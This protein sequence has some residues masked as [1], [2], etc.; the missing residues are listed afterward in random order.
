M[1]KI[2]LL[3]PIIFLFILLGGCQ[4]DGNG[5]S[6]PEKKKDVQFTGYFTTNEVDSNHTIPILF[7][8]KNEGNQAIKVMEDDFVLEPEDPEIEHG[9]GASTGEVPRF[10]TVEAHEEAAIIAHYLVT[11]N[12]ALETV[13]ARDFH[14]QY[15]GDLENVHYP[16]TL[17]DEVPTEYAQ[18][19]ADWNQESGTNED[20]ATWAD[21]QNESDTEIVNGF[22][23]QH[24]FKV[25]GYLMEDRGGGHVKVHI[26]VENLTDKEQTF[27][28]DLL[29]IYD[30]KQEYDLAPETDSEFRSLIPIPR[31]GKVDYIQYYLLID[32]YESDTEDIM[33][34]IQGFHYIDD[35][36]MES[37][38]VYGNYQ[39]A[40]PN[41]FSRE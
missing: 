11:D 23:V 25:T 12:E 34:D 26:R 7:V 6:D 14:L 31:H 27:D 3:I 20:E 41:D 1:R 16:L 29:K 28:A 35:Q 10:I 39:E 17:S 4:G 22:E 30:S 37:V 24:R 15:Y 36:I 19:A 8:V 33:S 2:L 32:D 13:S 9:Y 21:E 38:D 18:L 40:L 5:A